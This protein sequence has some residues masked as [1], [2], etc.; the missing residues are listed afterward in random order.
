MLW[1]SAL[2]EDPCKEDSRKTHWCGELAGIDQELINYPEAPAI[3]YFKIR[4]YSFRSR[5]SLRVVSWSTLC[6]KFCL[7]N[8]VLWFCC[9]EHVQDLAWQKLTRSWTRL[10]TLDMNFSVL[11][12]Q[13]SLLQRSS[14]NTQ[15]NAF[16]ELPP[17]FIQL[18]LTDPIFWFRLLLVHRLPPLSRS[19]RLCM[20][21]WTFSLISCLAETGRTKQMFATQ[22]GGGQTCNN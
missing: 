20:A 21:P 15:W 11:K 8:F 1:N 10:P 14:G 2:P 3:S 6:T 13:K 12:L 22:I 4:P 18:V 5:W 9:P 16:R 19:L 17:G 7:G